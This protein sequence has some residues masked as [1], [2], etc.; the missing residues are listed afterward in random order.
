MRTFRLLTILTLALVLGAVPL[1]VVPRTAVATPALQAT[2]AGPYPTETLEIMA[3]AAPGGGWD[4]TSREMQ[5][6]LQGG[7]VDQSVEVFNV[8]GAGG[9][10]GL[11]QL[12]SDNAGDANTLMMMG[13]VMVG[14]IATNGSETTL[15][16][17]TPVARL[18]TEYEVIVVPADSPYQSMGDLVAEL[19]ADPG[20]VA[21]AG[22]SAGGT[23]H[24]LVGLIA[25]AVGADPTGI[26]YIPYS[27]GGEALAALLSGEV[28]AGVSGYGEFAAQI[29]AGALRA[30]AISASQ[31]DVDAAASATPAAGTPAAVNFPPV[32]TLQ[33]QGVDVE[34]A[35]WRGVVAGPD[36]PEDVRACMVAMID[37]MRQSPAWQE[38]LTRYGWSDFFL[39]G[40]EFGQFITA[41][42]DRVIPILQQLG[43]VV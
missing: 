42:R 24:I 41:E 13:L 31:A 32:P 26:N 33:S 15:D 19:Q 5:T 35:N 1:G 36:V 22:G 28:Q 7:I 25:Q 8:E 30:L 20:A 43:L 39:G 29:E 21:W 3:P 16:D 27:G 9:T 14:A 6:V 12:V 4:T 34:L 18:T 2:C 37:T 10:I 38:V 40:D 17:V 23:D 11:A